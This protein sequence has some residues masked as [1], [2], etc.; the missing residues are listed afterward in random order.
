MSACEYD[1]AVEACVE[2]ELDMLPGEAIR[3]QNDLIVDLLNA[4]VDL[5]AGSGSSPGA[6]RKYAAARKAIARAKGKA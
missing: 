4:L 2:V 3:Y 5:E 6:K 1:D